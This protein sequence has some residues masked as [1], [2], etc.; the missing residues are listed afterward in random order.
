MQT[1][2]VFHLPTCMTRVLERRVARL[3]IEKNYYS[4]VSLHYTLA[5]TQDILNIMNEI[6][7]IKYDL[8]SMKSS[9]YIKR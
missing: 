8:R 9:F 1:F 2:K 6:F 3:I 7:T 5:S 4:E